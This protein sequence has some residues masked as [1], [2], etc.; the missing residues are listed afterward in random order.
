MNNEHGV[1]VTLGASNHTV[2]PRAEYDYYA[3]DPRKVNQEEL[4]LTNILQ[5]KYMFRVTGY[6][7]PR[8]VTL[9]IP[10]A[11]QLHTHGLYGKKGLM[12]FQFL[13]GLIRR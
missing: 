1:F 2:N 12:G 11:R 10:T 4:F 13:N 6:Y 3:T 9:K 8:M 7:V 5:R